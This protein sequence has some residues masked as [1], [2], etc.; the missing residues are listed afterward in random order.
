MLVLKYFIFIRLK[1]CYF[2]EIKKS[3]YQMM[4]FS[5]LLKSLHVEK[6]LKYKALSED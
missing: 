3:K 1:F 4:I 2:P 6:G 5:D